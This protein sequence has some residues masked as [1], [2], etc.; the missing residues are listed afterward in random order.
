MSKPTAIGIHLRETLLRRAA[1]RRAGEHIVVVTSEQHLSAEHPAGSPMPEPSPTAATDDTTRHLASMPISDV[2]TRCWP[3]PDADNRTLRQMVA[4]RLEAELPVPIDQLAW[5]YR[6][7][8]LRDR[9]A[10]VW[11]RQAEVWDRLSSRS[12]GLPLLSSP[13]DSKFSP[14]RQ[15]FAQAARTERVDRHLAALSSVGVSVDVLTTDAEALSSLYRHGFALRDSA[16]GEDGT[17]VLILATA[18]EWLVAVLVEGMVQALRRL[19]VEPESLAPACRQCQQSI[20]AQVPQ[21][22]LRRVLWCGPLEVS[23]PDNAPDRLA[24]RL[25]VSVEPVEPSEHLVDA[26]G[27]RI[28]AEQ[29]ATFGPAIGLALAG[30]FEADPIIHFAGRDETDEQPHRQRIRRTL[31]HPRRWTAATVGLFVLAVVIHVS[32][33]SWETRKMRTLLAETQQATDSGPHGPDHSPTSLAAL[34]PRIRAMQR[35]ET[36]RIDVEGIVADLCRPVPNSIV[37]SSIRLAR[38]RRLTIKGTARKPKAIFA[39]ADALRQGGR[40]T[41][42]NPERTEPAHGGGFTITAELVGVNQ[43]PAFA[44]GG[45]LWR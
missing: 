26:D 6:D 31:A 7:S 44:G 8:K 34:Q 29:F 13:S 45:G 19:R 4:H 36:Y 35:L 33:L 38:D 3:F 12:D 23:G 18:G 1:L 20:E 2:M 21:S 17:E 16:G 37:I 15:V 11:D 39:L 28:T 10:E 9:Q 32:A 27:S 14:H 25:G 22:E 43:L 41:A 5:A 30:L 42:V 24:E 40:F